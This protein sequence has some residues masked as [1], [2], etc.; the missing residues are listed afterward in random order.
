VLN[1][2]AQALSPVSW[3]HTPAL[4]SS[5]ADGFLETVSPVHPPCDTRALSGVEQLECRRGASIDGLIPMGGGGLRLGEQ[6]PSSLGIARD[7]A[8]GEHH[9]P[10]EGGSGREELR[11]HPFAERAGLGE[12]GVRLVEAAEN[13]CEAAEEVADRALNRSGGV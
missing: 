1:R 7:T 11:A 13:G 4:P 8:L 9:S 3:I 5:Q 2:A 10:R 12:I 6:L